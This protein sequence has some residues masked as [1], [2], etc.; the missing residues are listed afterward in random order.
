MPL[1][2]WW[3][4]VGIGKINGIRKKKPSTHPR[5]EI[6]YWISLV[7]NAC[8]RWYRFGRENVPPLHSSWSHI[9]LFI[10]LKSFSSVEDRLRNT[11]WRPT[12]FPLFY[13]LFVR[14]YVTCTN[15]SNIFLIN[16]NNY[17]TVW[18]ARFH[19]FVLLLKQFYFS[20]FRSSGLLRRSIA[21]FVQVISSISETS[22]KRNFWWA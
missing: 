20:I 6:S 4:K 10:S 11:S 12:V 3:G 19:N 5:L 21:L 17:T 14:M 16:W 15:V 13:Y 9:I 18:V 8:V 22:E 1:N 2:A 7:F